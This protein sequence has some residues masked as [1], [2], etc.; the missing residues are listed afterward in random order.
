MA[1]KAGNATVLG[2]NAGGDV[3]SIAGLRIDGRR[4]DEVRRIRT[5]FG[6]FSRVDGSSYYEQG[7]TKVV[8]VVY[9]PRELANAAAASFNSGAAAV[10]TGSG[11]ASTNTQPRATINC[12]FTQAAF[13]TS[14]R[15]PPRSGDRKKLEMSLAVKQI[16]EACIQRHLY[17]RSQIDI[18]VQVLHADGGELPA[19]INAIT[20]ALIDAGIALDDFVVASSAGYLQQSMLCDLNFAEEVARAP[21]MVIALNPRTQKLNLLQME[22]KLPLELFES[23]MEVASEGCN[24]IYDILQN[25]TMDH[26]IATTTRSTPMKVSLYAQKNQESSTTILIAPKS[27]VKKQDA[28]SFSMHGVT[29]ARKMRRALQSIDNNLPS[30]GSARAMCLPKHA[31][32]VDDSK[33]YRPVHAYDRVLIKANQ[34][35]KA[36]ITG[37][38]R[39]AAQAISKVMAPAHFRG[40]PNEQDRINLAWM[41]MILA[42]LEKRYGLDTSLPVSI[43]D[44]EAANLYDL[45]QRKTRMWRLCPFK[46][47]TCVDTTNTHNRANDNKMPATGHSNSWQI[48]AGYN[49]EREQEKESKRQNVMLRHALQ[50]QASSLN[51]STSC[52]C[53]TGCLKMYCTCFSSRGF[54]HTGCACDDCKNG[55]NYQV[56][57]VQAIQNYMDN[58]PRAFSYASLPPD[59]NASGF[60]H[61]L[62]QKSSA[63]VMRGCRCKRS[64]CLKKYCECFQ[65]NIACTS[66]CRCMDCFNHFKSSAA[67]HHCHLHKQSIITVYSIPPADHPPRLF[68]PVHVTVTKQPRRNCVAK[69][70]R[71]NL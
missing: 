22:C 55:R 7:N 67:H 23:L 53:K 47:M 39:R 31:H 24:Q 18:F 25:A 61:L 36:S 28:E 29:S 11:N 40:Y 10:G 69:T 51:S 21:Q 34:A 9:G 71:L 59:T 3:I 44:L 17:P 49:H 48:S 52:G 13:A 5:R 30:Q 26:I 35:T 4:S 8:A 46:S 64:K 50:I 65:N 57:R 41:D 12:D 27:L 45:P 63:V 1:A 54:C 15:K 70:V 14:E 60:L 43:T 19:S 38:K 66:H 62:P 32:A 33:P 2:A 56:E 16:F 68:H 6:L 37:H 42:L 58:N 20:L